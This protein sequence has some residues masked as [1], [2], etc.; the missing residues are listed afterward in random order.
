MKIVKLFLRHGLALAYPPLLGNGFFDVKWRFQFLSL[1]CM[2][3]RFVRSLHGSSEFESEAFVHLC[4]VA[5]CHFTHICEEEF[6]RRFHGE[7][8]DNLRPMF[9]LLLRMLA[10]PLSLQDQCIKAVRY[11]LRGP[12][13]L[14]EKV[15][16]LQLSRPLKDLVKLKNHCPG[17]DVS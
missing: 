9:E 17:R 12:P 16:A 5:G 14:W 7:K 8:Y 4:L 6:T 15:D 10:T 1:L 13:K 11:H 3:A 2:A